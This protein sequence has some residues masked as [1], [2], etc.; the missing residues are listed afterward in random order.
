M[1]Q[2]SVIELVKSENLNSTIV[3]TDT[4]LDLLICVTPPSFALWAISLYEV[5][6]TIT[7]MIW[8]NKPSVS[9]DEA[10]LV[11]SAFI[12]SQSLHLTCHSISKKNKKNLQFCDLLDFTQ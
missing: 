7:Q 6:A 2:N 5:Y 10:L 8:V 4:I 1:I 11:A 9:Y 3:C 12:L